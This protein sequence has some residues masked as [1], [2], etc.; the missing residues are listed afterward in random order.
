M[1]GKLWK[2]LVNWGDHFLPDLWRADYAGGLDQ[3]LVY[4][5]RRD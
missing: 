1:L 2:K 4:A 5:P 3:L